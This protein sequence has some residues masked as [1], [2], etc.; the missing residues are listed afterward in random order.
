MTMAEAGLIELTRIPSDGGG[1][2][3]PDA[4]AKAI[5]PKTKCMASTTGG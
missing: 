3:D 1:T 4:I 2:V 5:T